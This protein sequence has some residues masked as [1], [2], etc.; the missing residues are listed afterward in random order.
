VQDQSG[1]GADRHRERVG[2]GVVDRD[3]LQVEGSERDAVP[4]LDDVVDGLLE[5]VLPQLAAEQRQGQL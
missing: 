5:A 2:D 4:L 3:E 1:A